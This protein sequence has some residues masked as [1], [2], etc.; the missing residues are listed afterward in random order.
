MPI[1]KEQLKALKKGAKEA[2]KMKLNADYNLNEL[3][4]AAQKLG[5]LINPKTG[6]IK[7]AK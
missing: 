4:K 5:Y 7:E 6:E 2:V 1:P 3:I